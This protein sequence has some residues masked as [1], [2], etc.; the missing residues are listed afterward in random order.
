MHFDTPDAVYSYLDRYIN[1]ERKVD[2]KSYR[3]DR[4]ERLREMFGHPDRSYRVIH[5]AGSKGKGST[6]TMLASIA[7]RAEGPVGLYT[8]PH[9]LRFTERIAIDGFPVSDEILL[10]SAEELSTVVEAT[11]PADF[12]GNE[13]PTYFELLTMLAMLCFRRAGCSIAVFEVGLGGRLDSTNVVEPV[14]SIITSIELEHTELLGSTI[15]QIAA[16]KAGII[17]PGVPV[18]S[19][20]TDNDAR[21]VIGDRAVASGSTLYELDSLVR[22]DNVSITAGG[23]DS[24][25]TIDLPE[26]ALVLDLHSPLIG[27]VQMRNAA[28]AAMVMATLGYQ[29]DHIAEGIAL[30]RLPA[31]FQIVSGNPVVVLDGAHT[32]ESIRSGV[33]DFSTIFPGG[34]LLLFGCASDKP[35][36]PMAA[37]LRT[38]FREVFI[39]K[40]GTFKESHPEEIEAAFTSEGFLVHRDDDTRRAVL[41][42]LGAAGAR[43]VPLLVTGS[44]YLCAAAAKELELAGRKVA[45]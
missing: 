44:F 10:A 1:F 5:V 30:A 11:G 43:A 26:G 28:L 6:A 2:P 7:M 41:A 15:P 8:S 35:V 13:S 18:F 16:E 22:I 45:G 14:A 31:R 33:E 20:V 32:A 19:S 39:T 4:M 34:G 29:R 17:K 27:T 24:R 25:V 36:R 9:L 21:R 37:T 40:P 42:A 12:P 23:T 3:L 38:S